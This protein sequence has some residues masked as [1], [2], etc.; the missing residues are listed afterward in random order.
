[1]HEHFSP[2]KAGTPN[3]FDTRDRSCGRQ[4]FHGRCTEGW[5]G[6]DSSTLHLLYTW[7]LSGFPGSAS[8]KELT[9]QCRRCKRCRSARCPG[10]GNGNPLQLFLP[11]EIHGQRSLVGGSPWGCRVRH[12]WATEHHYLFFLLLHQLHLRSSGLRLQR[13]GTPAL[14]HHTPV[15]GTTIHNS[16]RW[17]QGSLDDCKA[18]QSPSGFQPWPLQSICHTA[19]RVTL[20]K[21]HDTW[22]HPTASHDINTPLEFLHDV[23]TLSE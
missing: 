4:L 1:M 20:M 5:F 11:G 19:A 12:H 22:S 7:L 9:C 8:D 14:K 6:A 16:L 17:L 13:S 15:Q 3:L 18:P 21:S 10:E 23:P 2:P